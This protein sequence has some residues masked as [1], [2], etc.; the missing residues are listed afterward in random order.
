MRYLQKIKHYAGTYFWARELIHHNESR[1]IDNLQ[2]LLELGGQHWWGSFCG[3]SPSITFVP[4]LEKNHN[5]ESTIPAE[6][7]ITHNSGLCLNQVH[8]SR[9][10]AG[11][12]MRSVGLCLKQPHGFKFVLS[13]YSHETNRTTQLTSKYQT[14]LGFSPLW[15]IFFMPFQLPIISVKKNS[16]ATD[17][18][19]REKTEAT[20]VWPSHS[21]CQSNIESERLGK[22]ACQ[23]LLIIPYISTSPF[24]LADW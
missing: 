19:K 18:R 15:V 10:E 6:E 11:W 23:I 1:G 24:L 12:D 13:L 3:L 21:T 20:Q 14:L 22:A 4:F 7:Q 9:R 8:K 2:K 5:N 17:A 16:E